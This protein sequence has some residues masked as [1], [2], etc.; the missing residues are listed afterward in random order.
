MLHWYLFCC[1]Y[2]DNEDLVVCFSNCYG[3]EYQLAYCSIIEPNCSR[4]ACDDS[5]SIICCKE[6]LNE[7]T[8]T[9]S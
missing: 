4:Y 2:D 6:W 8:Y 1:R 9:D 7:S 3:N 5:I